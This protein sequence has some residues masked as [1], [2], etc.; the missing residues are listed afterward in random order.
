M[1][2]LDNQMQSN[3]TL[4]PGQIATSEGGS[5]VNYPPWQY[6]ASVPYT[7]VDP[8]RLAV[9]H[10]KELTTIMSVFR[11]ELEAMIRKVL[12]ERDART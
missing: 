6:Q 1:K 11:D 7:L 8:L 5:D 2:P 12:D 9:E 3:V 10:A 4:V